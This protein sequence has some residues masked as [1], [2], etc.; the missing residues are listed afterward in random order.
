MKEYVLVI[1]AIFAA[2]LVIG[3]LIGTIGLCFRVRKATARHQKHT[4][5][6][7]PSLASPIYPVNDSGKHRPVGALEQ[8]SFHS[9]SY[10]TENPLH[11]PRVPEPSTR[12]HSTHSRSLND[13]QISFIKRD[14]R[15]N[16]VFSHRRK[17]HPCEF[18]DR[19]PPTEESRCDFLTPIDFEKSNVPKS[20]ATS[21][22]GRIPDRPDIR[23][24]YQDDRQYRSF[25]RS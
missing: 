20:N 7:V 18:V 4:V 6:V 17:Q 8:S 2:V 3:L 23:Y 16:S 5:H 9:S 15:S 13:I 19:D 24:I 11:I 12:S 21:I 22:Y 14:S 1:I 10:R 25:D